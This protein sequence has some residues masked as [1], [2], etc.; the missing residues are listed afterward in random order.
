MAVPRQRTVRSAVLGVSVRRPSAAHLS[1]RG[2]STLRRRLVVGGLVVLALGL[3][4]VSFRQGENGRLGP[5]HDAAAAALR[6]FEV[7]SE[8]VARP[9]R[10]AYNWFH[11]LT[12]ARDEAEALRAENERLRQEVIQNQLAANETR[13]LKAL[14]RYV[15]GP[16]FPADYTGL[17]TAVIARPSQPFARSI[18]VAVGS[19][20]GVQLN[21]PV[22]TADGL[23]GLVTRVGSSSSRVRLLTDEESAVSAIDLRTSAAGIVRHGRGSG[24]T[25]VL[26]RVPKE[27]KVR[28]GD[29]IVTAGTRAGA[30][31]S[32]Y[33]RGI[34]LG[35]VTSVGQADTDL[36]KQVQV[37]PF[38]DFSSLDSVLVLVR[39]RAR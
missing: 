33:P 3:I 22:V 11:G 15:Q 16:T 27:L 36:Y 28:V 21:A 2:S 39:K 24:S 35:E 13:R 38:A 31:S 9:F 17:A 20:D 18:V 25:L 37:Q 32:L 7:A 29:T 8:R 26:D 34:P 14:L 5:V 23:V 19:V 1:A 10:D 30:L 4:T 6:P 12:S